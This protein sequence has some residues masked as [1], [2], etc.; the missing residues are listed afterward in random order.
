MRISEIIHPK[1]KIQ[2]NEIIDFNENE[3]LLEVLFNGSA[4]KV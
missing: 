1:K 4:E 3:F 2:I